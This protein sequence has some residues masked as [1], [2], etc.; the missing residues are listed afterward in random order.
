MKIKDL[1]SLADLSHTQIKDI[2]TVADKLKKKNQPM[3]LKDKALALI[4]KKSSTRTRVS[5]EVAIYQLG[6]YSTFLRTEDV[7]IGRGESIADTAKVLSR[8][9]DG[10]VIRT[11]DHSEIIELAQNAT[12]P[13]INGL[14]D[15]SH[16]CQVLC[17]LMTIKEKRGKL[18][19]LKVAFIG[20]GSSNMAH[21]WMF[22]AVKMGIHLAVAT[23]RQYQPLPEVQRIAK[24]CKDGKGSFYITSDPNEA[25]K[26][27]DILYTDVFVSMGQEKEMKNRL[28][29][30][31]PYQI[32]QKL[33]DRAHKKCMVMHCLPAHRGQEIAAD[34]IDGPQSVVFDQAENRLHVQKGI[35]ALLMSGKKI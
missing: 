35:L 25:A 24:S 13:V 28:K 12:I 16:P 5:F 3:L 10:I 14:S 19:G 29:T 7:Q 11:F 6:G 8:Y 20:D 31:K 26:N 23:P 27:A 32:T 34:V 2:L 30:F 21:S 17:D 33:L 18:N 4:F 1:I 15:Y 22:G 9:I